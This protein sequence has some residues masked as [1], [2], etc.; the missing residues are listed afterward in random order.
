MKVKTQE[1]VVHQVILIND[2][3]KEKT[4]FIIILSLILIGCSEYAEPETFLIPNDFKGVIVIVFNQ[5]KGED[6]EY[7]NKRR[8]YRIPENGV[9]YTQFSPVKGILNEKF[10][11][12]N[13]QGEHLNEIN[14]I[15]LDK[16]PKENVNYILDQYDGGFTIFPKGGIK[17]GNSKDYPTIDYIYLTLDNRE[18]NRD[19]LRNIA[20]RKLKEINHNY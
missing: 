6:K 7:E 13:K 16:N 8:I 9:L 19:S 2:M 17:E 3:K 14:R 18:A 12:I 11:Y 10:Y 5:E 1:V 4:I 20:N 15:D